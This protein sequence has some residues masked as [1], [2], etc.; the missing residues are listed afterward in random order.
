MAGRIGL[1]GVATHNRGRGIGT[2]LV[3]RALDWFAGQDVETVTV[4]T[5]GRNIG[6]QSLYQRCG[7]IIQSHQLWYHK[8]YRLPDLA[9][10]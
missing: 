3:L 6:A 4:V 1:V 7:F 2:Q 8:W 9:T 5:Q 10:A